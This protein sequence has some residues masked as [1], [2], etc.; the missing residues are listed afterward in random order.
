[1]IFFLPLDFAIAFLDL[2][3]L[4][5]PGCSRFL[6]REQH[7]RHS[8]NPYDERDKQILWIFFARADGINPVV[9][10]FASSSTHYLGNGRERLLKKSLSVSRHNKQAPQF[11]TPPSCRRL[12]EVGLDHRATCCALPSASST[13]SVPSG[14]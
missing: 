2:H 3:T 10:T 13:K 1:M 5:S 7:V 11:L 9:F 14:M 4:F 12:F 8:F 6:H